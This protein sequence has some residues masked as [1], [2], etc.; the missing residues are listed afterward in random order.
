[1]NPIVPFYVRAVDVPG[2]IREFDSLTLDYYS[3]GRQ[4]F[5]I[6]NNWTPE[7]VTLFLQLDNH[8][9]G[10]HGHLDAGTVKE[11]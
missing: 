9:G 11:S 8:D 7:A 5:F 1:M 3:P 6:R 2:S 4:Y 10:G